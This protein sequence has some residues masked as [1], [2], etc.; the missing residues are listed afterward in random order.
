MA[1][2]RLPSRCPQ[3]PKNSRN[4]AVF[5]GVETGI[6]FETASTNRLNH[7]QVDA[8]KLQ[9]SMANRGCAKMGS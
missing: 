3:A 9:K 1:N 7:E 5:S 8:E 6:V 4:P 2:D